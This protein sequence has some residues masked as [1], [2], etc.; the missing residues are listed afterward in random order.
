MPAN[1]GD[2]TLSETRLVIE[3]LTWDW[4]L[5]VGM[6]PPA[7]PPEHRRQGGLIYTQGLDIT[8]RIVAPVVRDGEFARVWITPFG[9]DLNFGPHG[10][11]NVGQCHPGHEGRG[12]DL[13]ANLLLPHDLLSGVITCLSSVWKYLHLW[14][15]DAPL[16][17]AVVTDFAFSATLSETIRSWAQSGPAR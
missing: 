15:A 17:P 5:H 16:D 9:P 13:E 14:T 1:A 11:R 4:A 12:T 2:P 3:I 8:G 6:A 10:L 7:V